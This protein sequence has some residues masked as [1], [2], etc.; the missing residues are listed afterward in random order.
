VKDVS[1]KAEGG[2]LDGKTVCLK[3]SRS[4]CALGLDWLGLAR[5][6][7]DWLGLAWIGSDW[8]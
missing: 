4:R 5:I 7:S 1:G 3:V 6:G 2:I 8:L